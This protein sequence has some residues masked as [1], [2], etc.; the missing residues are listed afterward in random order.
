MKRLKLVKDKYILSKQIEKYKLEKKKIGFVPTLGGLH[1]GHLKLIRFAKKKSDVVIASIFLNPIQFNSKKDFQSY[2]LN[3][4]QD[5]KK[6]K[7]ENIDILYIPDIKQIFPEKRIKKI[8]ASNIAKKL[9][10]KHRNGHFDGVVTVLKRMFDQVSPTLVFFGEKDF[11]QIKVVQDLINKYKIKIKILT[12]PTVRDQSGLALSSRNILLNKKQKSIA[13]YL[14]KTIKHILKKAIT[15]PK[16]I[17]ELTKWGKIKLLNH[18]FD[19]I[20]YLEVYNENN[21]SQLNISNKN[22]RVFVAANLG[23]IRLIDNIAK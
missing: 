10:G 9:C 16:K 17:E 5:K 20:D 19:S 23:N 12:L 4:F 11:Q 1:K 8:K 3:I 21:F 2:P 7:L 14:F 15:N 18:G 6:I 22:L 13:P